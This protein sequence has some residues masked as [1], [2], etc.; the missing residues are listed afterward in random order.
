MTQDA[1]VSTRPTFQVD[2]QAREDLQESL[3][4]MVINLPLHGCAHAEITLTNWGTPEGQN[5]PDFIFANIGLGAEIDIQMGEGQPLSLFKGDVTAIE[6]Q[7]GDGAPTLAILLQDKLHRLARSRQ[8][9]AYEDY[10]PDDIVQAIASAAGLQADA[11]VSTITDTWHQINESDLAF[12]MRLLGHFDIGLRLDG[13]SLRAKPEQADPS[14]IQVDA[15]DSALL[16][17]LTVDLNHQPLSST[18]QGYNAGTAEAV[19]H[20]HDSLTPAPRATSATAALRQLSWPGDEVMPHPF[21]RSQAEAEAY[22]SA[23]FK[24]Q[25]KRFVSGDIV[26][27]GEAALK[28]GREIELS[29]VSP[30]L[31]GIYQIVHCAHRFDNQTGFETHLKVNKADW[32]PS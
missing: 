22:A 31:Q 30:R 9:R 23:H 7:Y 2:G 26:C 20:N 1:F 16:V 3:T 11:Q 5:D 8:N 29:G 19:D 17:R 18:V 13:N 10:S 25:A 12:L 27:Q 24:R 6:E 28:S 32:S 15:Q 4:G 14:P 21:A